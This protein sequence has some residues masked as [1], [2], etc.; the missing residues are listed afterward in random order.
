M[1]KIDNLA[2]NTVR[3]LAVESVQ[4]ANSGHPG[5]PMGSAPMA[6]TLWSRHL[7][8]NPKNPNWADR[9]RF[10]LSAGH[11]SMLLYSLLHLFGYGLT[12]EDLKQFRQ[13]DSKTPGHPEFGHT[14]GVETTTGPLGQGIA[15]AVGMAMA[16][17]HL[18]SV[19]NTEKHKVIDHYTYALTGDGCLMEGISS[20]A[21]SLAGHLGLGKLIVLYD[22]NNISIEGDTDL[23]FTEDVGKRYE[24]YGWQVLYVGDGNTDIESI[25]KAIAAAKA[26]TTKPSMIVVKTLIG[27]GCPPLQ[28]D[29][30]CHGA[31]LG[32]ENIDAMKEFL[33]WETKEAFYVPDEVKSE[34]NKLNAANADA[35]DAWNTLFAEYR[36]ENPELA[37]KWDTYFSDEIPYDLM[38]DDDFW[39]FEDKPM[40]TRASSGV[41]INRLADRFPNMFGGSADL[42]PSNKSDMKKRDYFGPQDYT[43]SNVH[44]GVRE[45]AMAAIANG[46]ALH[47]GLI[48]YVA[49]FFVFSDYLKHALRLAAI[50]GLPVMYVLTHDSIGV[51]EDGPTHEPIEQLAMVRAIPNAYMWRPADAKEAAAAYTFA[52]NAKA[53]TVLALTRQ[54]VPLQKETGKD[55]L[56]GG[57]IL[58]DSDNAQVIFIATGS[59]VALCVD[60]YEALKEKGIGS[61]VV[62]MPCMKLFDEQSAEYKE[63]VL[64]SSMTA[65]V[66][67]EAG[68]SFGW[69]K[70]AGLNG[71]YVTIDHFGASA[72]AGTLFKEFG[73]TVDNVIDHAM[74][75]IK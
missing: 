62:S 37:E 69:G 14:A 56:K 50:M 75:V 29:H 21:S 26:D 43:G 55:A 67:V 51:G 48:A 54:N 65:R 63:S 38:N 44:F 49:T 6:Y 25:D 73:F 47:G 41:L 45:F 68:T 13:W 72:P 61:R 1:S 5:L 31:P 58:K 15:N 27:Y 60:A 2:I 3:L 23:A 19:F 17:A 64:P 18:S 7:K 30:N 12:L 42:A 34:I 32:Q 53:P 20:E 40:A 8:H 66:V 11:G 59:E 22:K 74:N 16:E 10:V 52:I 57:Y 46:L 4:K 35:E 9:D 28:G 39:S 24:A 70:Y 36:K 71:S 33:G